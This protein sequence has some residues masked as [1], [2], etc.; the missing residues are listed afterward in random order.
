LRSDTP[1][2][3][4]DTQR[5]NGDPMNSDDQMS[6]PART[7]VRV[8]ARLDATEAER[9]RDSIRD[10]AGACVALDFSKVQEFDE[11]G[12]S[13]LARELSVA[14]RP[15]SLR[16]LCERHFRRLRNVEAAR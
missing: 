5:H 6:A 3:I 11:A 12:L 2:A 4:L 15:V 8:R 13:A 7:Y 10:A 16:G 14:A 1:L 9:I